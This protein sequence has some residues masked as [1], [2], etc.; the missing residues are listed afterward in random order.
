MQFSRMIVTNVE[1]PSDEQQ[2]IFTVTT[3][4]IRTED[5]KPNHFCVKKIE[6]LD[7]GWVRVTN[8]EKGYRTECFPPHRIVALEGDSEFETSDHEAETGTF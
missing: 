3:P 1:T 7:N 6:L 2:W 4:F 5:Q 8:H